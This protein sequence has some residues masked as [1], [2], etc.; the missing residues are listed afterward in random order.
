MSD[1]KDFRAPAQQKRCCVAIIPCKTTSSRVPDKNFLEVGGRQMLIHVLSNAMCCKHVDRV[2]ISTEDI[3]ALLKKAPLL[4]SSAFDRVIVVERPAVVSG[5]EVDLHTVTLSALRSVA[6]GDY[7][8]GDPTHVVIMQPNVPTL[9]PE[10]VD[11]VVAA[12]TEG[13]YNVAR[14]FDH[15]GRETGGCDAYKIG[16]FVVLELMDSYNF[17]VVS[18]DIEVN[19]PEDLVFVQDTFEK[20]RVAADGPK[21]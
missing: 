14:H 19:V 6:G 20:R 4:S 13:P 9:R 1:E 3:D 5:P 11:A 17:C 18:N 16:A 7:L 12:V 8:E 2:V 15:M 10:T 21:K